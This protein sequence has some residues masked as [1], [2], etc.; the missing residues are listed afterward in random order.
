MDI[1]RTPEE[2]FAQLPD[3]PFAPHYFSTRDG[4]QIH[5]VDEGSHLDEVVLMLHG[6]P[7][8]SYL[9]RHMISMVSAAGYRVIAPDLIGFGKS[10]KP[11]ARE[12]YTY[13]KHVDWIEEW[14]LDL[15]LQNITLFCQDWGGLI[16]LRM[17]GM[18]PDRFARVIAAN[19]FLPNGKGKM[20]A[21]FEQWKN[22]SQTV[23]VFPIGKILQ[24]A[25]V[26]KLS[27]EVVAA[28]DAPFPDESFK[29]GARVFPALVPA[30]ADDP[31]IPANLKAWEV[32]MQW[33]KPFLTAFSDQD[34]ITK[35]A[36]AIFHKFIPGTKGQNHTTIEQGGHF[37]QEDQ[38]SKLSQVIL[39]FI[40]SNP[41]S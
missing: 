35:G 18:H 30:S 4:L 21:A 1:L 33:N 31:A 3:Y 2:R 24:N 9:Y 37:L 22:F 11:A 23:P 8:W 39:D 38:S 26:S 19:T 15:D 36:D 41:L 5:Y 10:D 6:E 29:A 32:L 14:L 40:Q 28:Y 12:D 27:D 16:G 7:S 13:Q 20:P 17:V 25:T 34:P